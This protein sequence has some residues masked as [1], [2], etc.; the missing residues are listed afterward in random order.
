MFI[1]FI[2]TVIL[3]LGAIFTGAVYDK[4]NTIRSLISAIL[5]IIT[6]VSLLVFNYKI[7][8]T[9]HYTKYSVDDCIMY[10]YECYAISPFSDDDCNVVEVE[11]ICKDD[12]ME[13]FTND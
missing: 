11:S 10:K 12:I 4:D 6:A 13:D 7:T 1:N 8:P 2:I 9:R 5:T 3:I